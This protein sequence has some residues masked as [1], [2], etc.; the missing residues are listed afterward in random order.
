VRTSE[1]CL[2]AVE[3]L[4]DRYGIT[5]ASPFSYIDGLSPHLNLLTEPP[6]WLDATRRAAFE[7]AAFFGSVQP[8]VPRGASGFRGGP[9]RV[10]V[11]WGTVPWWYWAQLA[12]DAMVTVAEALAGSAEVL[13]SL[14]GGAAPED[15]VAAMR[16]AGATVVPYARTW[17]ALGEA[18]VFVTAQGL[19]SSH[20]AIVSRVPML[21]YPFH[22]DQPG[23]AALCEREGLAISLVDEPL[24]PL[25]HEVVR[26]GFERITLEH[27]G[28]E[29]ALDRARAWELDVIAQRASV[30]DRVIALAE[31]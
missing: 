8:D 26:G 14:G 15:R 2:Q 28:F 7:P 4:R 22:G 12:A 17:D 13:I 3:V 19:N 16:R 25:T 5:N 20:E 1:R 31:R 6:E 29:A 21:S 24:A 11:S 18:D 23:I 30:I 10:Y 27:R 9:P